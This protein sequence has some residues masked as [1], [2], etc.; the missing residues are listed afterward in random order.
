MISTMPP[1]ETLCSVAPN[2][3]I[4]PCLAKLVFYAL[5]LLVRPHLTGSA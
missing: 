3:V 1:G 4:N 5:L 2:V